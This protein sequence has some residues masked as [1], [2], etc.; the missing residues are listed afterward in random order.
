MLLPIL[1]PLPAS[2][3]PIAL[4]DPSCLDSPA[5]AVATAAAI[6]QAEAAAP[7]K[8]KALAYLATLNSCK[9]PPVEEAFLAAMEDPSDSVRI[10]AVQ[11]IIDINVRCGG[12]RSCGNGC[13]GCCTPAIQSKLHKLAFGTDEMGCWCESNPKVRRLARIGF[14]NC[15]STGE[16]ISQPRPEEMPAE[17]VQEMSRTMVPQ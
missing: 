2:A 8:V 11:G 12:C 16:P 13:G 14:C 17:W 6:Q 5:P 7:G 15:N 9:N 1:T 10:A 4:G 3:A